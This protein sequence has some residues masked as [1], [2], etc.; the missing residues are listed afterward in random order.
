MYETP[1]QDVVRLAT[2]LHKIVRDQTADVGWLTPSGHA[3]CWGR[4]GR[5]AG[6]VERATYLAICSS[7]L[8]VERP[9]SK[10]DHP[11]Q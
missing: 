1:A 3:S 11:A 5:R 4:T 10:V 8:L 7:A 6:D 9:K 2:T